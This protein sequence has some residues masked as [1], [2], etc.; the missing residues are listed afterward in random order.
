MLWSH[1]ST[2]LHFDFSF[3]SEKKSPRDVSLLQYYKVRKIRILYLSLTILQQ[4]TSAFVY[5]VPHTKFQKSSPI[6]FCWTQLKK[7][8]GRP[9]ESAHSYFIP[10]LLLR[11]QQLTQQLWNACAALHSTPGLF[12]NNFHVW[13]SQNKAAVLTTP[14][15]C[16]Q[17]FSRGKAML[18]FLFKEVIRPRIF[19][20]CTKGGRLDRGCV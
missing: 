6:S 18:H 8:Q 11:F 12:W 19:H 10:L 20:S 13:A 3:Y 14:S 9:S 2:Y 17:E 7:P 16:L 15:F 5:I 1:L 4:F